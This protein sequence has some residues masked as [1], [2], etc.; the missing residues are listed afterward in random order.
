MARLSRREF[1][2]ATAAVA[3]TALSASRV[4]GANERL[5]LGFIGI[6]NRGDQLLDAF[7]PHRDC[8][9]VAV[10]DIYRPYVEHAA[11]KAGAPTHYHDY[12]KLLERSD[13]DAVVIATP[14]HWHALQTI[15]ACQASKDVY[16]E[17]PA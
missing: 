4:L 1:T 15:H 2:S 5:R 3:I 10:C 6:G 14:D 16:V 17:K 12:R 7:Q 9:I 8:Q 11:H 13:I